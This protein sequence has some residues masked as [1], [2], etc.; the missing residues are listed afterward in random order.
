MQIHTKFLY[1]A[2]VSQ[3]LASF[4]AIGEYHAPHHL[5]TAYSAASTEWIG[6]WLGLTDDLDALKTG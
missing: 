5:I 4:P 6:G 2:F 1:A 3:I